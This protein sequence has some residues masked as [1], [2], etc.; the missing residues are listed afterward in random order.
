MLTRRFIALAFATA[1]VAP[2]AAQTIPFNGTRENVN[3]VTPPGGRCVP[4][5]F[6]TVTIAPGAISSTGT[7]TI[8]DF[9][10][11]Q[12][13]CI[14]SAPPTALSDG[15]FEYRFQAGDSIIGIYSGNVSNS[16]TPGVFDAVENLTVT[17]GT[18]R[19]INATGAITSSGT[20]R[21]GSGPT[22]GPIGI[23]MGTLTG[24]L[25]ATET[26]ASGEFATALGRPSAATGN[27]STAIGAFSFAPGERAT[28]LGSFA[29]GVGAGSLALGDNTFASGTG[30][31]ALG[32]SSV[33]SAQGS[34]AIGVRS[35]ATSNFTY[36]GGN[37]AVASG[38]NATAVGPFT[39]ATGMGAVALGN[40]AV[41][42]NIGS[43]ATG[44]RS[45]ATGQNGTAIGRLTNAAGLSSLALGDS[46]MAA[47]ASSIAVGRDARATSDGAIAMGA[48]TRASG[49]NSAV[50]GTGASAAFAG[51]TAVG[52]GAATT[53]AN[54]VT[55][56]ASGSSIR[57]GDIAASTAAQAGPTALATV[58]AT[59]TLGQNTTLVP[60]VA[61]LQSSSAAQAGQLST[62]AAAGIALGGRVD[63]LFDLRALD[64]RD[65]R[66][67]IAA[68][69]AIG[70]APMPSAPGRTSYVVN[71]AAFR[72]EQA[73]G[74]SVM[75]RLDGANPIAIGAGFS[76]AGNKNNAFKLGLAGEF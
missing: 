66:Q 5:F 59:G 15:R 47:N 18:G 7:S 57:V 10:S 22:G 20:L 75:H 53:A 54:Q 51:S 61:A 45:S 68:A 64:R 71:G 11:T 46:A 44:V 3:P 28:A 65:M 36:A 37:Q 33:S 6:N 31:I 72:G 4:P 23:F 34:I 62:L 26:T 74:G 21:F 14:D 13:H 25:A 52:A 73:I 35:Q 2:A 48:G 17:G 30:A 8:S 43:T 55:L 24:S 19:F 40:A 58:D 29:E 60:T 69:V 42:T 56:G 12:S 1:A 38:L 9:V 70:Q 76:L 49:T 39:Q 67:G 27:Y 63:A 32:Q 50:F 41:A 16:A